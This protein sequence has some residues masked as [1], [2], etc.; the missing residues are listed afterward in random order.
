MLRQIVF[1]GYDV[2]L[3]NYYIVVSSIACLD[4]RSIFPLTMWVTLKSYPEL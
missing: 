3:F 1:I 4:L 2:Q